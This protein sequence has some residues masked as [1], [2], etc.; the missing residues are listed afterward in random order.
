VL[1]YKDL[2]LEVRKLF[3]FTPESCHCQFII[4]LHKHTFF[5]EFQGASSFLTSNKGFKNN[6]KY[7]NQYERVHTPFDKHLSIDFISFLAS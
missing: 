6:N 1:P 4:D 7:I 5:K 2:T 3:V